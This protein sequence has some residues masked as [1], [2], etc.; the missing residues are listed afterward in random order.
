MRNETKSY[1]KY[2][3]KRSLKPFLFMLTVALIVTLVLCSQNRAVENFYGDHRPPTVRY[4]LKFNIPSIIAA[5]VTYMQVALQLTVFKKR[6]NLDCYY[7]MPVSRRTL[8]TV[9]YLTGLVSTLL[10]YT[11][12]LVL[13][14]ILFIPSALKHSP[15]LSI[16]FI[17]LYYFSTVLIICATYSFLAFA[18][19]RGNTAGDG[20]WLMALYTFLPG[21]TSGAIIEVVVRGFADK[22]YYGNG[23][24][25]LPMLFYNISST[26][27]DL[28]LSRG[29]S[30]EESVELVVWFVGWCILGAAAAIGF[31]YLF[32]KQPTQKTE[33]QSDSPFAF[34]ILIPAYVILGMLNFNY[35][36]LI[37]V[38]IIGVLAVIGYVVYRRG[39][40][41]KKG[42]VFVL[43]ISLLIGI[44]A[45]TVLNELPKTN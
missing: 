17:L 12:S 9:H 19:D 37:A 21:I 6:R 35:M 15:D 4:Y 25:I 34:K 38:I 30:D 22:S 26:F 42:D 24:G 36:E 1:V 23:S 27:E 28:V 45:V 44:I 10:V 32:G 18:F 5:V 3:I 39:F 43:I 20:R 31:V 11:A 7:T 16:G 41:I 33:E 13:N 40:H 14:L 2:H 29:I 8:G